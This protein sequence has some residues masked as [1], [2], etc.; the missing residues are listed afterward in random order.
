MTHPEFW[1]WS[2]GPLTIRF[3]GWENASDLKGRFGCV[4]RVVHVEP[5]PWVALGLERFCVVASAASPPKYISASYSGITVASTGQV[6]GVCLTQSA[7]GISSGRVTPKVQKNP[8]VE[9]I[10]KGK[11]LIPSPVIALPVTTRGTDQLRVPRISI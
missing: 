7:S 8:C 10:V 4:P 9:K 1:G 5:L 3:W 2:T 6:P 11:L